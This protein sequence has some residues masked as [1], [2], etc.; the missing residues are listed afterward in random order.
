MVDQEV[1]KYEGPHI[2]E[3]PTQNSGSKKKNSA[4]L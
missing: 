4:K 2:L 1:F 3:V